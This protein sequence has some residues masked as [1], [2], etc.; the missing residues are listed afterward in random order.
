MEATDESIEDDSRRHAPSLGIEEA[1]DACREDS[2][3]NWRTAFEENS[4]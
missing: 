2:V 4:V 3:G 1:V